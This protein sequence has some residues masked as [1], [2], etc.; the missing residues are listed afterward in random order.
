MA[1]EN[2]M[3]AGEGES[4]LT[5]PAVPNV[6]VR[7]MNSDMQSINTGSPVPKPYVPQAI[8]E[9]MAVIPPVLNTSVPDQSFQIPQADTTTFG[10]PT[11]EMSAKKN[12]KGIFTAIIV[13]IAVVGLAALGYFVI[14]PIFFA[15]QAA[16]VVENTSPVA[17][18]P[19]LPA[20]EPAPIPEATPTPE[21]VA[22]APAHVSILTTP[23]S[24]Q[25]EA[26][27]VTTRAT[28]A[29]LNLGNSASPS[30]T[31]M[32]YR[33]SAG[34]L[35]KTADILKTM[36]GFNI[37]ENSALSSA[38]NELSG[39]GFVYAD[40]NGRWLGFA[41]QLNSSADLASVSATFSQAFESVSDYSS[42][43]AGAPG[44]AKTW[45]ASQVAGTTNHRFLTFANSGFAIDYGWVGN[46]LVISTSF[47]GFKEIIKRLQ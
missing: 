44:A 6:D 8:P 3:G 14:Y 46:K 30:L 31:E 10:S 16:P 11:P 45:K 20:P 34:E 38:F 19:T 26:T 27:A 32:I 25:M 41:A 23:A 37:S 40:A 1:N 35:V 42:L 9:N 28:L 12:S 4:P 5:K 21:P 24:G 29:G 33:N 43:F 13:F 7:T 36:T 17:E 22:P 15:N 47:D 39:T 2:L 18:Q